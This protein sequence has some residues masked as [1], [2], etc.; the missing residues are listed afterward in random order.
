MLAIASLVAPRVYTAIILMGGT[1]IAR[2]VIFTMT[3]AL[4][5]EIRIQVARSIHEICKQIRK[6]SKCTIQAGVR[7]NEQKHVRKDM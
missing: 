3:Y 6:E 5:K 2:K 4:E 1:P 7:T